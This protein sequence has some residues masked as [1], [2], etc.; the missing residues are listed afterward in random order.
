MSVG[1]VPSEI[2]KSAIERK[3]PRVTFTWDGGKFTNPLHKD[4]HSGSP[5]ELAKAAVA[6]EV[7][8]ERLDIDSWSHDLRKKVQ[9]LISFIRASNHLDR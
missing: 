2:L 4:N 5:E 3:Y 7:T 1:D 6:V 9:K 8:A